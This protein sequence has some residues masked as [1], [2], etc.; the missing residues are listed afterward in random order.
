MILLNLI[1]AAVS[2][3]LTIAIINSRRDEEGALWR[4][5]YFFDVGREIRQL[6]TKGA[7]TIFLVSK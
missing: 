5:D 7:S 1:D 2:S 4:F 6:N 3:N